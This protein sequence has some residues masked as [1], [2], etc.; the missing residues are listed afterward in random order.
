MHTGEAVMGVDG[1][2]EDN[3]TSYNYD[4]NISSLTRGPKKNCKQ[5]ISIER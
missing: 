3:N 4:F 5:F 2:L 1:E